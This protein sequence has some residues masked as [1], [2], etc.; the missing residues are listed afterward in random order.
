MRMSSQETALAR[1]SVHEP[2]LVRGSHPCMQLGTPAV[3]AIAGAYDHVG[4]AYG[5]YADGDALEDPADDMNRF[6]HADTIVWNAIRA[7]IDALHQAGAAQLKILDAGCGPGAWIGRIVQYASRIGMDIDAVGFDISEGQLEIARVK[8]ERM[9]ATRADAKV[10]VSFLNHD[11]AAPLPWP[12][13]RFQIVLCN[14][15][16]LNHLNKRVLPMAVEE[17]CRVATYRVIA[18]VRSIGSPATGCIIGTED[19][20]RYHQDCRRG[21]LE[22]L[23]R[24][25]S[26]HV[27]TF[28]LYT[29][30]EMTSLFA[31]HA[32]V[33]D[34]RAVDLF[35][36]RFAADEHWTGDLLNA[37]PGRPQVISMLQEAEE[38]LCRLPAWR[39]HG[40]HLLLV[41]QPRRRGVQHCG[42]AACVGP[43]PALGT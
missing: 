37:L 24:D 22:L 1:W 15:V 39:D 5:A 43:A 27:L 26:A 29:A 3:S 38:Q 42:V 11:L 6:A 12:D 36:N 35:V 14:Y 7:A 34:V 18:S 23:L 10:S 20:T 41:A 2:D 17:L 28:N 32:V 33:E 19:V 40:T 21:E 9:T 25:G 8:M 30:E 4:N 16:V 13:G 31:R